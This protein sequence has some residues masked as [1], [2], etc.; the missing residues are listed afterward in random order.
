MMVTRSSRNQSSSSVEATGVDAQPTAGPRRRTG[1]IERES[2]PRRRQVVEG[3][4][5]ELDPG[6][7]RLR[8]ADNQ[9]LRFSGMAGGDITG[10]LMDEVCATS[11]VS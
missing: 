10:T 9:D 5:E 4:E 7:A 3:G 2:G 11:A 1:E 6:V 8:R